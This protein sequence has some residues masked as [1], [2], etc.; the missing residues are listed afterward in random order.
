MIF[1]WLNDLSTVAVPTG[2]VNMI[3]ISFKHSF[4]YK[5]HQYYILCLVLKIWKFFNK[6]FEKR[7]LNC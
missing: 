1:I 7:K 2:N 3:F 5:Y 6:F 4:K